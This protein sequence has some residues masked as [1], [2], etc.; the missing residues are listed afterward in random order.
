MR[1]VALVLAMLLCAS[2]RAAEPGPSIRVVFNTAPNPP[3]TYGDGTAIDPDKPSLMVEMLRLVGQRTGI[4]FEFQR[5]PWQRGLY[6]I[7]HGE[8][9]AI[10]ASSFTPDR[11]R[12]GAYPMAAGEVDTRRMIYQMTYSLFVRRGAAVRWDGSRISGL[13][14]PV[15]VTQ[16]FAI[17]QELK[18]M[19]VPIE[20]EANTVSN[21]RKLALG[22]IDA[23]AEIET[24]ADA[25]IKASPAEFGDIARLQPPLRT[26]P[27]YLMFSKRFAS[28]YPDVAERVWNAIPDV[29]SSAEY[30]A[31]VT[32]KYAQ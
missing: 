19:G 30:R 6:M 21:L 8:A 14:K 22:R 4:G 1:R 29:A 3:I 15:G 32:G 18:A 17:A 13:H 27:Y 10:F 31:L 23:Y 20:P 9:D 12:Y 16:D 7:E 24:L 2:A 26:R 28:S 25:A 11:L 5:V